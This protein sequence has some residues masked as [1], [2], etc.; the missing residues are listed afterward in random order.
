M[1][2][3]NRRVNLLNLA[4]VID[5]IIKE[6]GE[7]VYDVVNESVEEVTEEATDKLKAVNH[8]AKDG[9][10][11]YAGSW[12]NS[13]VKTSRIFRAKNIHNEEHY[14]LTHLL[15][16]G[17]VIR[18][19]TGRTFGRTGKYPHIKPVE[20]WAKKELPKRFKERLRD[21]G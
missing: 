6:Y 18:N 9:S 15:E 19:G 5:Q 3:R 21:K 1:A 7:D 11:A 12:T 2:R 20:K 16:K 4:P 13:D 8:W 10:G 17:H 14:R